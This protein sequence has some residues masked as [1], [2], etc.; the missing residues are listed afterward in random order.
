MTFLGQKYC[1]APTLLTKILLLSSLIFLSF[2]VSFSQPCDTL[3]YSDGVNFFPS[4]ADSAS[5]TA[6]AIDNDSNPVYPPLASNGITSDW[7]VFSEVIMPGDTNYYLGA[8]SYFAS[9]DQA[10]NWIMFGGTSIPATGAVLQW[11]H[12]ILDNNYRD[13][14]EVIINTVG[15]TINDFV[16]NGTVLFSVTDN[17]PSTDGDTLWKTL[18]VNI[19]S[20]SYGAKKVFIAFHHNAFDMFFLFLDN[21]LVKD[22]YFPC[23]EISLSAVL[24]NPTSCS[25]PNGSI[26]L[27]PS[28][29][30]SPYSYLWNNGA[31]TS[32][33]SNLNSVIYTVTVTDSNGCSTDSSF[34]LSSPSGLNISATSTNETAPGANNGTATAIASGGTS[35][36]SYNWSNNKFS[37]SVSNLAPGTYTVTVTDAG[38]CVSATSVTILPYNC[39]L[40]VTA[41]STPETSPNGNNG[42]ATAIGSGGTTPYSYNWS[43]GQTTANPTG[44]APGLHVVTIT[45]AVG[46]TDIASTQVDSFVCTF[47]ANATAT[48]E[49][50]IGAGDGTASVITSGGISPYTF[51]WTSGATTANVTGL[52]AGTYSVTVMDG[53]NC[54]ATS[55]ATVAPPPLCNI[56]INSITVNNPSCSGSGDGQISITNTGGT[57]TLTTTW[58]DGNSGNTAFNVSAGLYSVTITDINNC[59]A[60]T[61]LTVSQPAPLTGTMTHTNESCGGC[62]D[63]T[64]M[65]TVSGGTPPYTYNWTSGQTSSGITNLAAGVYGVFVQ[66]SKG[67]LFQG[68][69]TVQPAVLEVN[70]LEN[71][72]SFFVIYPNPSGGKFIVKTN[73]ATK[74][75]SKRIKIWNSL[76]EEILH[77]EIKSQD[78]LTVDITG[79]PDG[80]Y[81]LN[82]ESKNFNS[83]HKFYILKHQ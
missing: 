5:F 20:A 64:A 32:Q 16:N 75:K 83:A 77:R 65:I 56:L 60:D 13:G 15:N 9:P 23:P 33:I 48:G 54:L 7:Q 49:T 82:L 70:E 42:T 81:F 10:D 12:K 38:G 36:Y 25:S 8:T 68:S 4:P 35:P 52:S 74:E 40:S 58:S 37:A 6:K 66:D 62:N 41:S 79:C 28:G 26:A 19:D 18:S 46:C 44:L 11:Q 24:T 30:L 50:A 45:D 31:T 59:S 3:V 17:D 2:L 21:F 22:C 76:G 1:N 55:S 73:E 80:I 67:C 61:S 51:S 27:T 29:G 34:T 57:G 63:G 78:D 69:D 53:N 71:S 43:S 47:S 39:T 72:D 14:Y